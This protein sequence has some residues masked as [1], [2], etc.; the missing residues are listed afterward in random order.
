M[1]PVYNGA[2]TNIKSIGGTGHE[3]DLYPFGF[4]FKGFDVHLT[5]DGDLLVARSDSDYTVHC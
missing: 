5:D 1:S 3:E 2:G 4:A